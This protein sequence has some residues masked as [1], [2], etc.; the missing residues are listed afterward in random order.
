MRFSSFCRSSAIWC[1]VAVRWLRS[2]L[3]VP[4]IPLRP[5]REL[6]WL[7]GDVYWREQW[8][9][10]I[11]AQ[12]GVQGRNLDRGRNR[13]RA[14][15][16]EQDY[17]QYNIGQREVYGNYFSCGHFVRVL[18]IVPIS[19]V[20]DAHAR[21]KQEAQGKDLQTRRDRRVIAETR[22]WE[23]GRGCGD[24]FSMIRSL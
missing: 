11:A 13:T 5:I 21:R 19:G 6:L 10:D 16:Y 14:P 2:T 12:A 24:G 17:G 4:A 7:E 23:E 15:N 22:T 20:C 9:G 8:H 18:T 1:F 3:R